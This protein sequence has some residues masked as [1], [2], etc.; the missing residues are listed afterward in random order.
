MGFIGVKGQVGVAQGS[1]EAGGSDEHH[2][3]SGVNAP[4]EGQIVGCGSSTGKEYV[5][6][7][8]QVMSPNGG[9]GLGDESRFT[10]PGCGMDGGGEKRGNSVSKG[11]E[12]GRA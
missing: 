6:G 7:E 1:L 5:V 9:E 8:K 2:K 4:A 11:V 3:G 12:A 10:R